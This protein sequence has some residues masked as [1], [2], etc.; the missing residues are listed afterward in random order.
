MSCAAL[1]CSLAAVII[2]QQ[3]RRTAVYCC[4][5]ANSMVRALA[6]HFYVSW[7]H[8]DSI[9]ALLRICYVT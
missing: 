5:L 3:V 6:G 9:L 8:N 2:E 7:W 4:C 1:L